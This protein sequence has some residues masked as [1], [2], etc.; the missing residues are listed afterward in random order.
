MLAFNAGHHFADLTAAART[1]KQAMHVPCNYRT[2]RSS[3]SKL[4]VYRPVLT[5]SVAA[6]HRLS[7]GRFLQKL[8]GYALLVVL[9]NNAG[10]LLYASTGSKPFLGDAAAA[11]G[12][13]AD[14]RWGILLSLILAAVQYMLLL[15]RADV[16]RT[17]RHSL[18]VGNR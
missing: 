10:L 18:A 8:D 9:A 1:H 3:S 6:L 5:H 14:V 16:C 12:S 15:Q 13:T 7:C 11:A 4:D 2:T 17:H